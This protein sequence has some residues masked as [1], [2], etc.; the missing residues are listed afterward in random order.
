[1]ENAQKTKS[2]F[3][4]S[5]SIF[6]HLHMVNLNTYNI[7]KKLH[8]IVPSSQKLTM[9]INESIKKII[10][11]FIHNIKTKKYPFRRVV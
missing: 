9:V 1:M 6:L 2:I 10:C 7:Y 8:R 11:I 4:C 3:I 5:F